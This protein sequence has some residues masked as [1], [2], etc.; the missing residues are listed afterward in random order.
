MIKKKKKSFQ[1]FNPKYIL[2]ALFF[3]NDPWSQHF[4]K[5]LLKG[6]KIPQKHSVFFLIIQKISVKD[7]FSDKNI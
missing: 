4:L 1:E 7:N 3:L 6:L 2:T 5:A